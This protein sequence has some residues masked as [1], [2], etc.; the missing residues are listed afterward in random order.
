V[1]FL[2][3]AAYQY[4]LHTVLAPLLCLLLLLLLLAL[5]L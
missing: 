5:L 3:W 4:H 1:L 2:P